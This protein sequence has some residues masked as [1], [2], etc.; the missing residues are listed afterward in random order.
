M[1]DPAAFAPFNLGQILQQSQAAALQREQLAAAQEQR[2][3][4]RTLGELL[5]AALTGNEKAMA[6]VFS[7]DPAVGMQLDQRQ[8]E[9]MAQRWSRTAPHAYR[10]RQLP[11]EQRAEYMNRVLPQLRAFGW[12]EEELAQT[13]LSDQ[14]LDALITAGETLEQ[15][16]QSGRVVDYETIPNVGALPIDP[17]TGLPVDIGAAMRGSATVQAA[18]MSLPQVGAQ[19]APANDYATG[20]SST[21]SAAGLPAPVVAG[22]LGNGHHESGG[23]NIGA[24]GDGGTAH[25]A[26]QWR[27]ERAANFQRVTGVHPNQATPEQTARF[28][29]WELQNPEAAGMT[30]EQAQAILSARS[31]QEAALLVSRYY[32]R[33]NA[34]M[35]RNDRRV[36]LAGRYAQSVSGASP[37]ASGGGSPV[38]QQLERYM[39]RGPE[40]PPEG[41]QRLPDG[42]LAP[43]PGSQQ[44]YERDRNV[45]RDA[46]EARQEIGTV[47]NQF[48][49]DPDVR[50]W[51]AARA[52]VQQ[53]QS[54]SRSG[55]AADDIAIVYTFMKAL[56]SISAVREGE[57]DVAQ[58]SAG[59]RQ[60]G[61]AY[62][63]QL[64][65]GTRLTPQQRREMV[66]TAGRMYTDLSRVYNE[67]TE[68]YREQAVT[69]GI[70]PQ[71]VGRMFQRARAPDTADQRARQPQRRGGRTSTGV[72]WRVVQ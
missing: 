50:K 6:G 60:R 65:Q 8:R 30:R 51:R 11:P 71:R 54:L 2:Q 14:G 58:N 7:A 20:V 9:R 67:I 32:E 35:A 55:S 1:I 62:L 38:F 44:A 5:P 13:D 69:M 70:P 41:M 4:R 28:V 68:S 21:L 10:A 45:T 31:P 17:R 59:L 29:M 66:A 15:A 63:A 33:P 12:T 64:Q 61:E 16:R 52:A 24:A 42:S 57:F 22:F 37:S 36:A 34:A 56:D 19:T 26:F 49:S 47:L 27:G 23:W 46:R 72:R 39:I 43:I 25:G 48:R 3:Q 53:L 40:R 18:P